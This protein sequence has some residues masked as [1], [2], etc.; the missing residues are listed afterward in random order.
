MLFVATVG[1]FL[2]FLLNRMAAAYPGASSLCI[3]RAV[4]LDLRNKVN[5]DDRAAESNQCFKKALSFILTVVGHAQQMSHLIGSTV[6]ISLIIYTE[7]TD[8]AFLPQSARPLQSAL[9]HHG[10]HRISKTVI[11]SLIIHT[12]NMDIA[13]PPQSALPNQAGLHPLLCLRPLL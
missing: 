8:I 5:C 6:A 7:N 9:G 4:F 1:T 2:A 3:V 11:T 13:T 12:K 10:P